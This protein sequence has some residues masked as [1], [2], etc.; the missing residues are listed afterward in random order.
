MKKNLVIIIAV[1]VLL[2][3]GTTTALAMGHGCRMN[4]DGEYYQ[5]RQHANCSDQNIVDADGDGICD[6]IGTNGNYIDENEDG[7]CDNQGQGCGNFAGY[8]SDNKHHGAGRHR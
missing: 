8:N 5:G 4:N 6:Y 2:V 1:A 3:T 7:I